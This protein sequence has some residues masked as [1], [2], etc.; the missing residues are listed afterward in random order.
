MEAERILNPR[1]ASEVLNVPVATLSW[2]RHMGT[3]PRAFKLS[4]RKV[5]YKESDLRR[6]LEERYNAEASA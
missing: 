3:G 1:Q 4:A 6:W 5:M 2:W